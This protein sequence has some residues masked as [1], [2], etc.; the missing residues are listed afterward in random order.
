MPETRPFFIGDARI[1][2]KGETTSRGLRAMDGRT[3]RS[4]GLH[5]ATFI[6]CTPDLC[7]QD[8][9]KRL[10]SM[11]ENDRQVFDSYME[12]LARIADRALQDRIDAREGRPPDAADVIGDRNLRTAATN[13]RDAAQLA[14][15]GVAVAAYNSGI[16]LMGVREFSGIARLFID[17]FKGALESIL[18]A[19]AG[20]FSLD[21]LL[22]RVRELAR[23]ADTFEKFFRLMCESEK[24]AREL[25]DLERGSK[26]LE[27]ALK[28]KV[29]ELEKMREDPGDLEGVIEEVQKLVKLVKRLKDEATKAA[30]DQRP[31]R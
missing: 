11:K 29:D 5:N 8:E 16:K 3:L 18:K 24:A 22:D 26:E 19:A 9:Q 2:V 7:A 21:D 4:L 31:P 30:E 17:F 10:E 6:D 15:S 23:I 20:K 28:K 25:A 13:F 14:G 1:S 12:I 27:D